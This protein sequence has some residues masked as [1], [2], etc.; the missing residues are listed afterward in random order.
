[1]QS[2]IESSRIF[3]EKEI[4]P[5]IASKYSEYEERI[6]VGIAGEGSDCFGY[7]DFMSRDHD[8]G[9]GV[10]LW[11]TDDDMKL[12]G[13][14]LSEDYDRLYEKYPD[15][16]LTDRLKE[17]RGVMRSSR[18]YNNILNCN[19]YNKEC[20][21][22]YE[23]WQQLDHTCLATAVNGEVFRDDLGEFSRFRKML[24]DYY[25]DRIWKLRIIEELHSFSQS[26]QVNYA[27]CMSRHDTVAAR[28]CQMN[29]INSAMQLYFLMKREYPPYYKWTYK[30]LAELDNNGKF[31]SWIRELSESNGE[32]SMWE[33]GYDPHFI[34]VSDPIVRLCERIAGYIVSMMRD[35]K[36]TDGIDNYLET[37]VNEIINT[38]EL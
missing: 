23:D 3:Y 35:C 11:L 5:L 20:N 18:F 37:Y 1:M 34:N 27:R 19:C 8:F 10:C 15:N 29:G 7:D 36:L 2:S 6:A 24:L 9:T 22:T 31:S 12:F 33:L 28:L 16:D 4:A 25:P 26:L 17:R 21:L 13:S 32:K 30:R 14:E 38:L